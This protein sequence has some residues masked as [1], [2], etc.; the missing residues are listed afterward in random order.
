MPLVLVTTCQMCRNLFFVNLLRVQLIPNVL[1]VFSAVYAKFHLDRE[2]QFLELPYKIGRTFE[3]SW[4]SRRDRVGF[5]Q[6]VWTCMYT[7]YCAAVTAPNLQALICSSSRDNSSTTL[8]AFIRSFAAPA[9]GISYVRPDDICR[10]SLLIDYNSSCCC[11][12]MCSVG[13]VVDGLCQP[14]LVCV[15]SFIINLLTQYIRT[16][17]QYASICEYRVRLACQEKRNTPILRGKPVGTCI[18]RGAAYNCSSIVCTRHLVGMLHAQP[19]ADT[20]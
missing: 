6:S 13:C 9:R 11:I 1:C 16:R 8:A 20:V 4:V 14:H 17:Y 5:C 3:F 19:D 12:N 18:P 10:S 7:N 2:R 15:H